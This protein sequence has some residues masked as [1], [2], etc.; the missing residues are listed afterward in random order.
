MQVF[1]NRFRWYFTLCL[2]VG[3]ASFVESFTV[4]LRST[5]VNG[6][7]FDL[8]NG[9]VKDATPNIDPESSR[10][11]HPNDAINETVVSSDGGSARS[12]G[13]V[14][15][16][17]TSEWNG[18]G[19][20]GE[21]AHLA[22]DGSSRS[23]SG[24]E[25]EGEY[26]SEPVVVVARKIDGSPPQA[27]PVNILPELNDTEILNAV[28]SEDEDFV[29]M[30]GNMTDDGGTDELARQFDKLS[31]P[32]SGGDIPPFNEWASKKVEETAKLSLNGVPAVSDGS[33]VAGVSRQ[34]RHR[35]KNHAS[36]DCSA[37]VLA[38]NAEANGAHHVL[39]LGRDEYMLNPCHARV[40]IVIELCEPVQVSRIEMSNDELYSSSVRQFSVSVSD[41]YPTRDWR[42]V[43]SFTAAEKRGLQTF[44]ITSNV[45]SKFLRLD[46]LNHYD[47]TYYYCTLSTV[48]VYG[49]NEYEVID[50]QDAIDYSGSRT[51]DFLNFDESAETPDSEG[52]PTTLIDRAIEAVSTMVDSARQAFATG[53]SSDWHQMSGSCLCLDPRWLPANT[54]AQTR[55]RLSCLWQRFLHH[56]QIELLSKQ[57][58]DCNLCAISS[59]TSNASLACRWLQAVWPSVNIQL[60]CTV[61]H[62]KRQL[63]MD[64]KL[65][66]S[67][68]PCLPET[69][70]NTSSTHESSIHHVEHNE[71]NDPPLNE[72]D[73]VSLGL[74]EN[75]SDILPAIG[76][77][78]AEVSVDSAGG[79]VSVPPNSIDAELPASANSSS[80]VL[81]PLH[82]GNSTPGTFENVSEGSSIVKEYEIVDED[83]TNGQRLLQESAFVRLGNRIRVLERN[84]SLSSQYLDELS[85][86]YRRQVED[87]QKTFNRTIT[88]LELTAREAEQ[89]DQLQQE[90]IRSLHIQ[91]MDLSD[92]VRQLVAQKDQTTWMMLQR[93]A[94]LIV[95]ELCVLCVACALCARHLTQCCRERQSSNITSASHGKLRATAQNSSGVTNYR[96]NRS[97]NRT[98]SDET[99]LIPGKT[100]NIRD[101][102]ERQHSCAGVLFAGNGRYPNHSFKSHKNQYTT[103]LN[104]G[105]CVSLGR[106]NSIGLTPEFS[107][108][109]CTN[110]SGSLSTRVKKSKNRERMYPQ[111]RQ[112]Y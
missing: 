90:M 96:S 20:S 94:A 46:V 57:L 31:Q 98:A 37:K 39:S 28:V 52:K 12:N 1:R 80:S 54:S 45:T 25:S 29:E 55:D 100:G 63:R 23:A 77:S 89:R 85:R 4:D 68:S 104:R 44:N 15:T 8:T 108:V 111:K 5:P 62:I 58:A 11:P 61:Y 112:F 47:G 51:S 35:Q 73:S 59:I 17:D 86:R 91:L 72:D 14:L 107:T 106:I 95:V 69:N 26:E 50:H 71:R 97:H 49:A 22:L 109:R 13:S 105:H 21:M 83:V 84:M 36:L 7:T 78:K 38:S 40:F 19:T 10:D 18:T 79:N 75:S 66:L 24:N 103:S 53:T 2:A 76:I 88:A 67:N 27:P 42:T 48:R 34:V 70:H 41:R 82:H 60:V 81:P 101:I 93:H 3:F 16:E 32:A 99:A 64:S 65:Q 102:K 110:G 30:N 74:A 9:E 87:M 6:S 43:A 56:S 92:V 33:T